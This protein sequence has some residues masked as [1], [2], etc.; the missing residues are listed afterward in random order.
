[1]SQYMEPAPQPTPAQVV[2]FAIDGA[3][4]QAS[5]LFEGIKILE[6]LGDG[7]TVE[8]GGDTL[9]WLAAKLKGDADEIMTH[10]DYAQ[11]ALTGRVYHDAGERYR[12]AYEAEARA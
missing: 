9:K 8:I 2:K 4:E 6:A 12:R 1:M 7:E 5:D 10:M 3:H 11:T